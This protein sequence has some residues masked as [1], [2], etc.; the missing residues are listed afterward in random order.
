[1]EI[2][3]NKEN[4]H[5]GAKPKKIAFGIAPLG[6]VSVGIV[7]MGVISIGVVP[8]GVF[9]FGAVAMGI[10]NLSVVGMGIISA[11]VTTMGIWEYSPNSQNNHHDHSKHFSN[12]NK[13]NMTSDLFKT[14]EEAEQAAS[15]YGCIGAHKMG[16]KWMPCKMH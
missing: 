1:M 14:K 4:L 3:K 6:I 8:M 15:K 13:E 7:P 11:G 10:L 5:C 16:N 2:N 9:S 12:S